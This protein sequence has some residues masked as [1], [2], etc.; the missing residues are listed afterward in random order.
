MADQLDCGDITIYLRRLVDGD[1]DAEAPLADAVYVQLQRM[2]RT[3]LRTQGSDM[4]LQPTGLVNEVLLELIRA[5]KV[6]WQ[7][8]TH[9][10]RV[11]SRLLRRRLVDHIRSRNAAKRPNKHAQVE[12]EDFL[13]PATNRFEEILA[14]HE[15]LDQLATVDAPLAEL[16]EMVYFG[17][18]SIPAIANMRGVSEKTVD[19]HLDL[20]RRWLATK[21]RPQCPQ[22]AAFA[23]TTN[24]P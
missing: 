8:R 24:E 5:R 15:G 11:A 19:R 1:I 18:I 13:L 10:Y 6:D 22:S 14:V 2:A 21:F 20:G 9:F 7:D 12:L 17:G 16:I 4:S 3:L 23:A